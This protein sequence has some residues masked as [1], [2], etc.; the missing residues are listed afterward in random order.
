MQAGDL[1][2]TASPDRPPH[3]L[4]TGMVSVSVQETPQSHPSISVLYI[5]DTQKH[6]HSG[7]SCFWLPVESYK[8]IV[9]LLC[10]MLMD[11]KSKKLH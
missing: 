7:Q 8:T 9:I 5:V 1:G 2:A 3:L 6:A 10:E 11:F 4:N